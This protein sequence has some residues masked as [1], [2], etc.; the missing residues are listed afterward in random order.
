MLY[1]LIA[2]VRIL[3]PK[4]QMQQETKELATTI[5][6][7]IIENRGVVRKIMPMGK[8]MLPRVITKDQERH[9]QA[10]KFLM[11][12]DSSIPVQSQILRTLRKDP[13]VIRSSIVKINTE[14]EL[15][16]LSSIEKSQGL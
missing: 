6:R 3:Q 15:A 5:G 11:L 16:S 1:E 12:F 9:F 4:H 8:T 7:M 13:R 14:K 10:F 2:M